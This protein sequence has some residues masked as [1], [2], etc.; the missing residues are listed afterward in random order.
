MRQA[1]MAYFF[2]TRAMDVTDE[3]V[4]LLLES[5]RCI[6]PQTEKPFH[7]ARLWTSSGYIRISCPLP[8]S[9]S[10]PTWTDRTESAITPHVLYLLVRKGVTPALSGM[11]GSRNRE[12]HT[13]II[14]RIDLFGCF[15]G[16]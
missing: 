1:L 4:R 3:A 12:G 15:K 6:E 13:P 5:I 9:L 8:L 11:P 10:V 14:A 2:H 7:K 16:T